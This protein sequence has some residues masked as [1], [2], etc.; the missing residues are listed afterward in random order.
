MTL[1][2]PT[3]DQ[4]LQLDRQ[5]P[6]AGFRGQ[7]VIDDPELIY[8]D[9]NS[10][11][12]L[13]KAVIERVQKAVEQEWGADLIRG[14]N[15]GWWQAPVRVGEKIAPLIG[16]AAGQVIVSDQTSVNLFKL[17]AA[18]LNLRPDRRRI[19]T[20]ALNFP[21]DLYVLQGVVK[22]LSPAG[23]RVGGV[24]PPYRNQ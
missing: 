2:S 8:L 7:F 4:A 11:G 17:A 1:F 20:D 9:G 3:R 16:A 12:R 13:P 19:V 5:D 21:S 14:W 23:G 24:R 10:L 18:A 6:L 15:K 22:I